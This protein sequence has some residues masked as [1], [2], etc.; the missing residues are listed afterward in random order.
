MPVYKVAPGQAMC[1]GNAP[2]ESGDD[3]AELLGVVAFDMNVVTPISPLFDEPSWD[4]FWS[5]IIEESCSCPT[6]DLTS[7]Q[8][9]ALRRATTYSQTCGVSTQTSGHHG[10][11]GLGV[12]G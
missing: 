7:A 2:I 3:F 1:D 10:L 9:E 12:R 4:S 6:I 11:C 8:L 5:N